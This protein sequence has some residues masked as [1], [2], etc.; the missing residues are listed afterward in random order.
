[1]HAE[2]ALLAAVML[3]ASSQMFAA[4]RARVTQPKNYK[5]NKN[6]GHIHT[7]IVIFTQLYIITC[8]HTYIHLCAF[9]MAF[10]IIFGEKKIQWHLKPEI[11]QLV[12]EKWMQLS[13]VNSAALLLSSTLLL[14]FTLRCACAVCVWSGCV[15]TACLARAYEESECVRSLAKA[16]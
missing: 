5:N 2:G 7:H 8:I 10:S 14:P 3:A 11:R 1:M 15:C 13:S 6:A 4:R 12:P 16:T 9:V